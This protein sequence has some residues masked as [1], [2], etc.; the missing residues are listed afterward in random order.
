MEEAR[1]REGK[2]RGRGQVIW[3]QT[4]GDV[5]REVG[6]QVLAG[7]HSSPCSWK[8]GMLTLILAQT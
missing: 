1:E 7:D 3:N 6:K 4:S 2:D 8:A 5:F